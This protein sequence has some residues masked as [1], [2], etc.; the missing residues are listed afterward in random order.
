M[1]LADVLLYSEFLIGALGRYSNRK[2]SYSE[3]V[4]PFSFFIEILR[5]FFRGKRII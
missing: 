4:V 1:S 5:S 3:V 2:N